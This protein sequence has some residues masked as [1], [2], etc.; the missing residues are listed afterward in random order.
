MT[1]LLIILS[2]VLGG[3]LVA[4]VG[5]LI[6]LE[7][8]RT[9]PMGPPTEPTGLDEPTYPDPPPPIDYLEE[10]TRDPPVFVPDDPRDPHADQRRIDGS[11]AALAE[12]ERIKGGLDGD[13]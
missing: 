10:V 7:G 9:G 4:V 12:W 13:L 5:I 3:G 8:R 2:S 6:W 1:T 11:D